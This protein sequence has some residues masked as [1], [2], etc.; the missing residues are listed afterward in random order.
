[1]EW[2]WG[3]RL[4][5]QRVDGAFRFYPGEWLV[6]LPNANAWLR[7]LPR[8]RLMNPPVRLLAQ[9]KRS[10]GVWQTSHPL[11]PQDRHLCERYLP[12]TDLF[13][14]GQVERYRSERE[15][16]VL[17]RAFGRMG[18]SVLI[19]ALATP[20]E[21]D[22]ALAFAGA[23]AQE[24]AMQERFRVRP[25]QFQGGP[26]Y[27]TIGAY[28]V[29]GKFAGYYSRVAAQPFITHEAYYVATVVETA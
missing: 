15:Q 19:G 3:P 12:R 16:W 28:A 21:W 24:F 11:E 18:D 27:P 9:S 13:D 10:F 1:M 29:N 2:R 22:A 7:A 8:L 6:L 4:A 25:L 5:G 14:P 20:A 17:K 23:H 26:M